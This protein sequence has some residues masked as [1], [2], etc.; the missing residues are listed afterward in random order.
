MVENNLSSASITSNL[1]THF[2]GQRVIYYPSLTSTMGVAKQ[3]ARQGAVEGMVI[4]ADEQ[5][6]GRGRIKRVWLS[7]K[8]NIALSIILYHLYA[9]PAKLTI[10]NME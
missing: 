5:T 1:G 2:I 4:I 9:T 3:E 6:A 7:P 10:V 8:G